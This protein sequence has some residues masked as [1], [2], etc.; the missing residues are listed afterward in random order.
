MNIKVVLVCL[1]ALWGFELKVTKKK[2]FE[3][4]FERQLIDYDGDTFENPD[5]SD[6]SGDSSWVISC[7]GEREL[8]NSCAY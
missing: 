6:D 1:I 2:R 7:F 8:K 3:E 5:D 4:A